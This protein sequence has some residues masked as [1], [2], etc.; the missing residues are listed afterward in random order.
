QKSDTRQAEATLNEQLVKPLVDLNF[1]P[2]EAYPFIKIEMPDMEDKKLQAEIIRI[3][4]DA[5]FTKIPV[6]FIR[7]KFNIP[8]P[9]ENEE[10]LGDLK[11]G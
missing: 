7:D 10:T 4:A 11:G 6:S 3:L 1:G 8:A 2:Q 5:G 9:G